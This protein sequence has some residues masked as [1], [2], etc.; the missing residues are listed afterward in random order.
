VDMLVVTL[1][2]LVVWWQSVLSGQIV[3]VVVVGPCIPPDLMFEGLFVGREVVKLVAVGAPLSLQVVH[4]VI[5]IVVGEACELHTVQT[6][7][8]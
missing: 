4:T 5:V 6:V 2:T 1:V 3:V 8:V 7:T